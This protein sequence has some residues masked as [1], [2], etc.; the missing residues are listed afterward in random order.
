MS[1]GFHRLGTNV[2]GKV[3]GYHHLSLPL[4][5]LVAGMPL[6]PMPAPPPSARDAHDG[7]LMAGEAMLLDSAAAARAAGFSGDECTGCGKMMMR[8]TGTCLT[9]ASCGTTTSCA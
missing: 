7:T 2:P 9:C 4:G 5:V 1:A 3:T 8:R 6:L